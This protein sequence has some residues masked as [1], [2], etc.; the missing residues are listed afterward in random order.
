MV[1]PAESEESIVHYCIY[2]ATAFQDT[3]FVKVELSVYL[4]IYNEIRKFHLNFPDW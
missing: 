3:S 1:S 2:V 4:S